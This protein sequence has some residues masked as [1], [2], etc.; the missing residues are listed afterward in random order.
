[1]VTC[2]STIYSQYIVFARF[3]TQIIRLQA[4][5]SDYTIKKVRLNNAGEFTS[6]AFNDY[7]MSIGIVVEHPV[8][9][10]HTQNGLA[11]S[12][13]KRLQL[14]ARPLIMRTKLPISVWGHAVLYA[15]ALIR[16]RPSAYHEYSP[17][18]LAFGQEPVSYTHLT[19]PTKRIV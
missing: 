14:I 4:Q 6:Q 19:L 1:M 12:L 7:C 5:F 15:A 9:H 16:I 18:Q 17:L 13:V 8:A 10:V 11:K 2:L 3:L